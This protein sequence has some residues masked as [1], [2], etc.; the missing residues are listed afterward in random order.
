MDAGIC[1]SICAGLSSGFSGVAERHPGSV[2]HGIGASQNGFPV[3]IDPLAGI[4]AGLSRQNQQNGSVFGQ[5]NGE[6]K[7][8]GNRQQ[9]N[10]DEKGEAW[11]GFGV[12]GACVESSTDQHGQYRAKRSKV[13]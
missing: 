12:S 5:G 13:Q 4:N 1:M 11:H 6:L 3:L 8:S 9:S 2:A 10:Q 7:E